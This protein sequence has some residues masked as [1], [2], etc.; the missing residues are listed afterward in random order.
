MGAAG[1]IAIEVELTPKAPKRLDG[2]VKAWRR[3]RWIESARY[4]VPRGGTRRG[5]EQA[6]VRMRAGDRVQVIAIEPLLEL[7]LGDSSTERAE[8]G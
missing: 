6:V 8:H 3:A 4:Y 7:R 5:V 2:I 1:T